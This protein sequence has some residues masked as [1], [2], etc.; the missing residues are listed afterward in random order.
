MQLSHRGRR[1]RR[2]R[3]WLILGAVA[4]CIG[5]TLLAIVLTRGTDRLVRLFTEPWLEAKSG[6]KYT[7]GGALRRHIEKQSEKRPGE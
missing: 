1:G 3:V 5:G 2:R 4:F 7:P 6:K